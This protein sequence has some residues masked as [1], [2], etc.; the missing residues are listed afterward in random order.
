M[1][2]IRKHLCSKKIALWL[3]LLFVCASTLT[4]NH[5]HE[6]DHH[7]EK[8]HYVQEV[9]YL[10]LEHHNEEQ[11]HSNVDHQI[12]QCE[13]Y[14]LADHQQSASPAN[15]DFFNELESSCRFM[16]AETF[17]SP[18]FTSPPARAPPYLY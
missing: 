14:H 3:S 6:E 1:H 9:P 7:G 4:A 17:F 10:D 8:V 5:I 12:E 18:E 16:I 13:A 15:F 2:N 11:H